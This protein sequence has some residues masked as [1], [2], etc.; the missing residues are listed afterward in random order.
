M[1]ENRVEELKEEC[2]T[3]KGA[4]RKNCDLEKLRE[5]ITLRS[6][7]PD[8]PIIEDAPENIEK[9]QAEY[10]KLVKRIFDQEDEEGPVLRK[11]VTEKQLAR[12]W[13]L[14]DKIRQPAPKPERIS[15]KALPNGKMEVKVAPGAPV[16]LEGKN[17]EGWKVLARIM[18]NGG[19]V[20]VEGYTHFRISRGSD[21][22]P[23]VAPPIYNPNPNRKKAAEK[24]AKY[25]I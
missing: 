23:Y 25:N 18:P 1:D 21:K 4:P 5:L 20:V 11:G 22:P 16:E 13:V 6:Q 17:E 15:A 2:L 3:K 24:A 14:Q 10:E 7:V 12:F 8:G 9:L 19:R